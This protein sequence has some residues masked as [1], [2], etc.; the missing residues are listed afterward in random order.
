MIRVN[1]NLV[2]LSK[3]ECRTTQKNKYAGLHNELD[4]LPF[5]AGNYWKCVLS[6]F[7]F[8]LQDLKFSVIC[9]VYSK[10][11]QKIYR[12]VQNN[13]IAFSVLFKGGELM[14]FIYFILL[15]KNIIYLFIYSFNFITLFSRISREK[16]SCNLR[17]IHLIT[18]LLNN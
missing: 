15:V 6:I 3:V 7:M 12:S 11:L 4:T 17:T 8:F 5:I 2:C 1:I 18:C 10:C 13:S 16:W 14:K 9:G